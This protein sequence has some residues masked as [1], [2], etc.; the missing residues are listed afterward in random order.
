MV[1]NDLLKAGHLFEI[2]KLSAD[3][4]TSNE[5]RFFADWIRDNADLDAGSIGGGGYDLGCGRYLKLPLQEQIDNATIAALKDKQ[6]TYWDLCTE[7]P[8][9]IAEK[10]RVENG[11]TIETPMAEIC[12]T[13]GIT[14]AISTVLSAVLNPGDEVVTMYPDF[15]TSFGQVIA[16]RGKLV[17][18]PSFIEHKGVLDQNRWQFDPN[19]L[20]SA[21]TDKTKLIMFT[22]PNNPNG[23]VY[24]KEDLEAIADIAVRHDVLVLANECYE[25]LVY[26]DVFYETLKFQSLAALPGMKERV[27]TLQGVSKGYH[28]SGYRV[29]W[30][31]ASPAV[32]QTMNFVQMWNT[33]SMAPTVTQYGVNEALKSPLRENYIRSAHDIYKR[34]A[35]YLCEALAQ[36][37]GVE[38]AHP[39]GGPFCFIDVEGTGYSDKEM[40]QM[41]Y[42]EGVN[43]SFGTPW[44]LE[45]GK[46][47]LRLALSN[48]PEYHMECT[49]ALVKAFK[50]LI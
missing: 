42:N 36:V 9:R 18:A 17:I 31:V 14:P 19:G 33:F 28:L 2:D 4:K 11:I 47:H 46:N 29:G 5:S 49:D 16:N 23:Y 44:G 12:L 6:T 3:T 38:C 48:D 39:R 10:L 20:E 34:N 25:R 15:V 22:N 24:S 27:I 50:K 41:L 8:G 45:K 7:L 40:A 13:C 43:T 30:I 37:H 32:I 35:A 1:N 21:I 26:T